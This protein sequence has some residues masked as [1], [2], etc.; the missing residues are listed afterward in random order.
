MYSHLGSLNLGIIRNIRVI[1]FLKNIDLCVKPL[2][3]EYK[4][5]LLMNIRTL[6]NEYKKH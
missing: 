2:V 5:H 3:N 6:F 1:R 4:K